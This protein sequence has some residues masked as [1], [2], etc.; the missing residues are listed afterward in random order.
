MIMQM[1]KKKIVSQIMGDK[2]EGEETSPLNA[3]ALELLDC[4]ESK[5]A[6]GLIQCLKTVIGLLKE[7]Q[8]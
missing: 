6:E 7:T 1:D 2:P 4:I 5:D 3:V 8:E